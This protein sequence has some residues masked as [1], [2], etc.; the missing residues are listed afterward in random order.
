MGVAVAGD[1]QRPYADRPGERGGSECPPTRPPARGLLTRGLRT[2]LGGWLPFYHTGLRATYALTE[3]WAVSLAGYNGWDTVLDNNEEKSISTQLTYTRPDVV[4]SVLF[5][6]GVER[7]PGAPE[8]RPWRHLLDAHVTWHPTTWLSLLAHANGGLEP[9]DLGTSS[10]A[11]GALYARFTMIEQLRAAVRFDTF[12]E[13][14]TEGASGRASPIF[15]PA[16]WVSSATA[17]LDFRPHERVSFRLEYRHDHA[18]ADMFFG[19]D[20]DG[21]GEATPYVPNRRAQD[22]LSLGATSWF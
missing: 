5:F 17:T 22:T 6:T 9:N 16:S 19:G 4:L 14:V 12:Y 15:W 18:G 21:D 7:P 10:W 8:G 20:V 1:E 2:K 13:H 11:A 3:A